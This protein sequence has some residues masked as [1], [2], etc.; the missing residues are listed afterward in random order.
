MAQIILQLSEYVYMGT[1]VPIL[2]LMACTQQHLNSA[3]SEQNRFSGTPT[4]SGNSLDG[5]K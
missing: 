1:S 2:S 4:K 5:A 3:V